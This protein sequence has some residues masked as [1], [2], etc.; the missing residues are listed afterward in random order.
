MQTYKLTINNRDKKGRS[1]NRRLRASGLIPASLYG[2]GKA[3]SI[4]VTAVDFR[5]LSREVGGSAAVVEL[6]DEN[7]ELALSLVQDVQRDAVKGSINHI[8]FQEI[9]RGHS[10]TTHVPVSLV[11]EADSIGV[12]N[13]GGVIDHKAHEVE[14][15]C[16]PS[17]LPERIEVNVSELGV[18]D[19]IHISD[20]EALE[21]VEYLGNPEQVIVSV[22]PPTINKEPDPVEETVAADE[23]PAS[24]VSDDD[25]AS[26]PSSD[27]T[28]KD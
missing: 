10:F 5:N 16:R 4:S 17:K 28:D 23:V 6:E 18:G 8:D 2:Q 12:K 11:G 25:E 19:A 7:G 22:Q 20:L 27:E 24:R 14:I 26:D 21:D 13:D 15:R 9:E 1:V 3:R